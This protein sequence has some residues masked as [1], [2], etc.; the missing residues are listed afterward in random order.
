MVNPGAS[1]AI[2]EMDEAQAAAKMLG[3]DIDAFEIRRAEDIAP[4]FEALKGRAEAL[5]VVAA[6]R[7]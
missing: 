7:S 2:L 5:Y 4:A 3:L 1:A 6:T